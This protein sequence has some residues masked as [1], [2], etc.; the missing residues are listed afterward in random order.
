MSTEA[1]N[2]STL[3]SPRDV[4]S[5]WRGLLAIMVCGCNLRWGG[6]CKDMYAYVRVFDGRQIARRVAS[7]CSKRIRLRKWMWERRFGRC[8]SYLVLINFEVTSYE[9]PCNTGDSNWVCSTLQR[10]R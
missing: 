3:K 6:G 9:I 7:A 10:T 4:T 2:V 5:K 1:T 8:G